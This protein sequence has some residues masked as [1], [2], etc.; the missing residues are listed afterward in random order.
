MA[1]AP[2]EFPEFQQADLVHLYTSV[3]FDSPQQ[4]R[5]APRGKVVS[6]GGVPQEAE[7][8]A[9]GD[10]ITRA[11]AE[12]HSPRRHGDAEKTLTAL[13]T[14]DTGAHKIGRASCRERV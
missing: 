4:I 11:E 3:G 1:L 2:G 12:N 6:A 8:V 7:H 5:A 14:E 13:T 10:M 9:H